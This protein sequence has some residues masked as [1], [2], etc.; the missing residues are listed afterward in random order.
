[1]ID[2]VSSTLHGGKII[3]GG[4]SVVRFL[5]IKTGLVLKPEIIAIKATAMISDKLFFINN[6][7][8]IVYPANKYKNNLIFY[9]NIEFILWTIC[10]EY[11]YN[12][13]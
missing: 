4:G 5:E 9:I 6:K 2:P 3:T 13:I 10:F 1:M 7:N 8:L 12:I 11:R